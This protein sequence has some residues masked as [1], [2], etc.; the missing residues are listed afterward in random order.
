MPAT[1]GER[2]ASH[3]EDGNLIR[4]GRWN[5][6]WDADNHLR[7]MLTDRTTAG[8]ITPTGPTDA[9][10][11]V[12]KLR[13]EFDYDYLGRCIA[14]RVYQ[15][16]P[17]G[18][19]TPDYNVEADRNNAANWS[20][21]SNQLFVYDGWNPIAR[22]AAGNT[23]APE[24]TYLWGTDLSGTMQG[25]GGVGGLLS[26]GSG[27]DE[28]FT[29][30]DGNGNIAATVDAG[31]A[32]VDFSCE[33]SAFGENLDSS[34]A[35]DVPFGFSTKYEDVETGLLYYGFRY[36]EPRLGRWLSRDPIEEDGGLNLYGFVGN[37]PINRVDYLGRISLSLGISGFIATPS[38]GARFTASPGL[39][40]SYDT[41]FEFGR[42]GGGWY[43][44]TCATGT[45]KFTFGAGINSIAGVG[46]AGQFNP[47]R[48]TGDGFTAS[49][50]VGVG[51]PLPGALVGTEYT[52]E[53]N[54]SGNFKFTMPRF[55][56]GP[57]AFIQAR[58]SGNCTACTN[59]LSIS[60][61][62]VADRNRRILDCLDDTGSMIG[63]LIPIPRGGVWPW[64]A[65]RRGLPVRFPVPSPSSGPSRL[66]MIG[67]GSRSQNK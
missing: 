13:L 66:K 2:A 57:N 53:V 67:L 44:Q 45:V 26:V 42:D 47:G 39:Q 8:H 58:V 36:Y 34:R 10:T 32:A 48:R 62:D 14:K 17:P 28:W 1:C 63:A 31:T 27:T 59:G 49:V 38:L 61:K 56:L 16:Q 15:W 33:Y 24:Q 3:D 30:Y 22:Y 29:A 40:L 43:C 55:T 19:T 51:I 5:Y 41:L 50:G 46:F 35:G 52:I 6:Q 64:Q 12:P 20:E 65:N 60:P 9:N 4:D 37:A 23:T 18:G 7:V 11:S 25:A 21:L 54:T